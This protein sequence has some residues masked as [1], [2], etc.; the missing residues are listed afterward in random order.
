MIAD[1]KSYLFYRTGTFLCSKAAYNQYMMT[2]GGKIVN[3]IANMWKGFPGMVHTGAARAGV[4]NMSRTLAIEWASSGVQINCVAPVR[5]A[6][7]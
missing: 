2:H 6:Y 3:I 4:E 5:N 7:L 1:S